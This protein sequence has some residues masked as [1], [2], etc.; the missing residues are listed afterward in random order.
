MLLVAGPV[1]AQAAYPTKPVRVVIRG[2][3]AGR[4]T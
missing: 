2:P 4:T 1:L 3:R